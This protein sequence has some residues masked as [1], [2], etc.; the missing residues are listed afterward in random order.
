MR[1]RAF[2][3][4]ELLFV[5]IIIGILATVALPKFK[6]ALDQADI[7]KAQ[8]T[9]TAIRSGIQVQKNKNVLLGKS[10]YPSTLDTSTGLFGKVLP[11]PVT[12]NATN[13]WQKVS[14]TPNRYKFNFNGQ[15]I[16][17]DYNA[18]SGRF[19]CNANLTPNNLCNN[20]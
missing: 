12:P 17:F 6:S 14:G 8:S 19:D 4:I 2:T 5:I 9:V 18:S 15:A 10:P 1:F 20:F 11:N 3:I 13:G 16:Y 7:S